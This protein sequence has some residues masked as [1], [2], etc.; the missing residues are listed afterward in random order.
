M[1]RNPHRSCTAYFYFSLSNVEQSLCSTR[2]SHRVIDFI[3][4]GRTVQEVGSF[5]TCQY[6]RGFYWKKEDKGYMSF[7]KCRRLSAD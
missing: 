2:F 3:T 4:H 1:Y 7:V 5:V 6:E